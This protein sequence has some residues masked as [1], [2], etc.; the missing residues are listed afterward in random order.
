MGGAV[1]KAARAMMLVSSNTRN[2]V[3]C[4]RSISWDANVCPYCGRDYRIGAYP[5][6]SQ[7]SGM[8]GMRYV[9]YILSF[10]IPLAGIIIGLILIVTAKDEDSKHV[11]KMCI[12]IALLPIII[13]LVCWLAA[14]LLVFSFL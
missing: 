5:S 14:G 12:L 1:S 11:G 3:T 13:A 4:G 9:L 2:C 7:G 10:F 8:G 6:Q